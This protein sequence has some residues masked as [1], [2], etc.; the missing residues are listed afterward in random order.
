MGQCS[1]RSVKSRRVQ[2]PR[3]QQMTTIFATAGMVEGR[4]QGDGGAMAGA[5]AFQPFNGRG[6]RTCSLSMYEACV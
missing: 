4:S 3:P 5:G 1:G 6:V 2:L